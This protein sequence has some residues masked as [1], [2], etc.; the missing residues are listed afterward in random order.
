MSDN[1][2]SVGLDAGMGAV[3]FWSDG[4]G[5]EMLSQVS[6]NGSGHLDTMV[7]LTA[8]KRP[9]CVE[10]ADGEFYTGSGAY[11]FGRAISR[12]LDFDRLNGTPEMRALVYAALTRYIQQHGAF[13]APLSMMV[14]L[15]LKTMTEDMKEYRTQMRKWLTGVHEWKADG[16]LYQVEIGAVRT[17]SQPVG[18]LFNFVLNDDGLIN[19]EHSIFLK[20]EV[21]VGIMSIGFKTLE[22]M[23]VKNQHVVESMTAAVNLGVH[24]LLDLVGG[25]KNY[26]LGELDLMARA[27]DRRVIE[28]RNLYVDEVN[29]AI[30]EVWGKERGN[31]LERVEAVLLVGGG[32]YLIGNLLKLRGKQLMDANPV[33]SISRG[34]YLL[35]RAKPVK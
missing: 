31:V 7:G 12:N 34:L 32:P 23:V 13:A 30:E 25:A 1:L 29:G 18:A 2:I 24:R 14:G 5:V 3:K 6:V 33:M 19:P 22:F 17:N 15:S 35:N 21:E 27:R 8:A 10:T 16:T 9:L 28:K 20:P 26:Q 4:G 11:E